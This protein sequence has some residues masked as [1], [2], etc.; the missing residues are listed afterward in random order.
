[1][2]LSGEVIFQAVYTSDLTVSWRRT[3]KFGGSFYEHTRAYVCV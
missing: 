1:V 3:A 2:S